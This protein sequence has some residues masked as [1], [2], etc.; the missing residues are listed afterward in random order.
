LTYI[1][2]AVNT[3]CNR[4]FNWIIAISSYSSNS[5]PDWSKSSY[6]WISNYSWISS[7]SWISSY[8]SNSLPD[9]SKLSYSWI[10]SC[11]WIYRAVAGYRATALI[12]FL[13]GQNPAIAGFLAV[14]GYRAVAGLRATALIRFLIGQ[15]PA[16]AG[17]LGNRYD[18]YFWPK[19]CAIYMWLMWLRLNAGFY[20]S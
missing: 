20:N 1:R 5:L 10:S 19:L 13:I 6:S 12:R 7:C 9:W 16:T 18:R 14:A 8:S 11:S 4:D 17:L 3:S 2:Y 15:N